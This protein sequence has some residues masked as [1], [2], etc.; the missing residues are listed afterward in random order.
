[1][2]HDKDY[3]AEQGQYF[4]ALSS[5]LAVCHT[6]YRNRKQ[7]SYDFPPPPDWLIKARLGFFVEL[8]DPVEGSVPFDTPQQDLNKLLHQYNQDYHALIAALHSALVTLDHHDENVFILLSKYSLLVKSIY[9]SFSH[10]RNLDTGLLNHL[11]RYAKGVQSEAYYV[12]GYYAAKVQEGKRR[13]RGPQSRSER[14]KQILWGLVEVHGL[15]NFEKTSEAFMKE[16]E[17]KTGRK[18]R[19]IKDLLKRVRDETEVH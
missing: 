2:Q 8:M 18:G 5:Y 6:F 10:Q 7:V 1:M 12:I 16:A 14:N 17:E 15:S 11:D 13:G 9:E 4:L 3:L 19:W